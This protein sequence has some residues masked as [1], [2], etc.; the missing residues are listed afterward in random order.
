MRVLIIGLKQKS[1]SQPGVECLVCHQNKNKH[2]ESSCAE[3]EA[4]VA[5]AE[6]DRVTRLMVKSIQQF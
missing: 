4:A 1:R 3:L 5:L 6:V 2:I